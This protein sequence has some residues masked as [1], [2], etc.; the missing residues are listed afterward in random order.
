MSANDQLFLRSSAFPHNTLLDS[1]YDRQVTQLSDRGQASNMIGD[2]WS[3]IASRTIETWSGNTIAL[4]DS[5]EMTVNQVFRLDTTPRIAT[6]AS[7]RKLQNPD[8]IVDGETDGRRVL[9][10]VDAKFSIDTAKPAQVAAETLQALLEVGPLITDLLPGLPH[11]ADVVDG[12]F[13]SPDMPLS[14]YVMGRHKGRLSTRVT[15]DE[16]IFKPIEPVP[17]LKNEQ[18]SRLLGPLALVD[19]FRDQIRSNMLLAMYYFRLARA[20]YGAYA[21]TTTPIFGFDSSPQGNEA[22]LEHRT[23]EFARSERSAWEVVL[24]WDGEAEQVRRQREAAY[25]AMA[26]PIAN[27]EI[28]D[29]IVSA[30]AARAV[31]APSINS[32]RRRIGGWYRAQFDDRLGTVAPPVA[33]MP[34]LLTQIHQI[35]SDLLPTIEPAINAIVDEVLQ[36]QPHISEDDSETV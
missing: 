16:V 10:A 13:L 11:D 28:R 31:V 9:L 36:G 24:R 19:G 14:H 8:F 20:C 22:E 27:R 3:D 33:D 7:R 1:Y 26:F 29:K 23:I 18:G 17:F 32:V 34:A 12:L 4:P 5:S 35:A 21:E 2:R 15:R 25:G 6:I 30:S